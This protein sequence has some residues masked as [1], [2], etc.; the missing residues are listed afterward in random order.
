MRT[1]QSMLALFLL[2]RGAMIGVSA[3]GA[4]TGYGMLQERCPLRGGRMV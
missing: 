1:K 4:S 3:P 2:A